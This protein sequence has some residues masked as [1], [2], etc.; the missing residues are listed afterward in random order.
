[1]EG[2]AGSPSLHTVLPPSIRPPWCSLKEFTTGNSLFKWLY[3]PGGNTHPIVLWDVLSLYI[4]TSYNSPGTQLFLYHY[5]PQRLLL[6]TEESG[7]TGYLSMSSG[8]GKVGGSLRKIKAHF[9]HKRE[10]RLILIMI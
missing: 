4:W 3:V 5:A 1:M 7:A 6:V 9:R 10:V 8:L 2:K